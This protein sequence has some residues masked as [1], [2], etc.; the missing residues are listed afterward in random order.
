MEDWVRMKMCYLSHVFFYPTQGWFSYVKGAYAVEW[1]DWWGGNGAT[2]ISTFTALSW[3][4]APENAFIL[5]NE[6]L[7][8]WCYMTGKPCTRRAGVKEG[9]WGYTERMAGFQRPLSDVVPILHSATERKMLLFISI[10][11][12]WYFLRAWGW[13]EGIVVFGNISLPY[14]IC[15][16]K[17]VVLASAV[18]FVLNGAGLCLIRLKNICSAK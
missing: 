9:E 6:Q 13:G 4:P 7:F 2:H 17:C 11:N 14:W 12:V 8:A 10:C 3:T 5:I 16:L 18:C 1:S 15:T